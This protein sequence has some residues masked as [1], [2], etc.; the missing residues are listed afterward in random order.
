MRVDASALIAQSV[1]RHPDDPAACVRAVRRSLL[2][3]ACRLPWGVGR[4]T[5]RACARI[6][7]GDRFRGREV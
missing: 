5:L 7:L 4:A 2:G 6:A 3:R 1:A